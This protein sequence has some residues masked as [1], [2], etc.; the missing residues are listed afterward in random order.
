MA[1]ASVRLGKT[2]YH[3][4]RIELP[5]REILRRNV[6]LVRAALAAKGSRA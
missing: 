2:G 5:I 3:V 1:L 6:R 4:S